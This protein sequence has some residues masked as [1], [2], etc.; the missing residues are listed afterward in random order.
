[1]NYDKT[2]N[3]KRNFNMHYCGDYFCLPITDQFT[4]V[5]QKAHNT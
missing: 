2:N 3:D 5:D 1:M 4:C